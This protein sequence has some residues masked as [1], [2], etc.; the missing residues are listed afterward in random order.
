M[1]VE[2]P[3]TTDPTP[4]VF[5]WTIGFLLVGMAWGFTTPFMRRTPPVA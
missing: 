3:T 5:R 4:S 2:I 1:A